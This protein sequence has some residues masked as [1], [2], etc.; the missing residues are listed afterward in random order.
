M[1]IQ[2]ETCVKLYLLEVHVTELLRNNVLF[3]DFNI[4]TV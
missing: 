2:E 1:F 4:Q 3:R